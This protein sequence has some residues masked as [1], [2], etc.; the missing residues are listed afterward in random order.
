MEKMKMLL[1]ALKS[2]ENVKAV[3]ELIESGKKEREALVE[4]ATKLGY[5]V[6]AEELAKAVAGTRELDDDELE[7]VSGGILWFGDDAPDGHELGC[8]ITYYW[9]MT[10]Y[11]TMQKMGRC[12]NQFI[13][14]LND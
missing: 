2:D 10:D 8:F 5:E 3:N 1:E 12:F 4:V 6:T 14:P 11:D 7:N 13:A 9:D